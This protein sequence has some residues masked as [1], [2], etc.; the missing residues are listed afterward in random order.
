METDRRG[1]YDLQGEVES[2]DAGVVEGADAM[3]TTAREL[4]DGIS[5][6]GVFT[7]EENHR[8]I[9]GTGCDEIQRWNVPAL[10]GCDNFR[11]WQHFNWHGIVICELIRDSSEELIHG[12]GG[13]GGG[14][15][16]D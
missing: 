16:R 6:I 15:C 2:D 12:C 13:G 11:L 7:E 8:N 3:S 5:Q 14:W 10:P 4:G 9:N 1:G